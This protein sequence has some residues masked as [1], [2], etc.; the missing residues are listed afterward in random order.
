MTPEEFRQLALAQAG[1]VEQQHMQHPDFRVRGKIFATLGYPDEEHGV[2]ILTPEEQAQLVTAQPEVFTP[3]KG[4]W[5][6]RGS[7]IVRLAAVD[8]DT[9]ASAMQLAWR[10]IA[11]RQT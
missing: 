10:R 11:G 6:R 9:L 1:A 7:T 3:V 2:L 4:A 5:G 8:A